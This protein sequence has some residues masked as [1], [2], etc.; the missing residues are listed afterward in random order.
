M[1][2]IARWKDLP[3]GVREHLTERMHQRAISLADLNQLRIWMETGP[4]VPDED[5]YKDFGSFK[6][7]GRGAYPKTFLLASQT[8]T[9]I[10]L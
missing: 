7:C 2:R 1:P 6:I 9:G 5:W 4:E 8:A 10:A 3:V